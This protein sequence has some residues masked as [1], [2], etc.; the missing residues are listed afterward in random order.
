[1]KRILSKVLLSII[2]VI[3]IIVNFFPSV[4]SYAYD[5]KSDIRTIG[6]VPSDLTGKTIILHSNDVHGAIEKYAY[7]AALKKNLQE[8]G[9]EVILVD[10]GDYSGGTF[11]VSAFR[12]RDAITAMNA[13]DYDIA[14]LG[15]HEFDYGYD[16][17]KSNISIADFQ[18]ICA[19]IYDSNNKPIANPNTIYVTKSRLKLGLF[20]LTTPKTKI[21]VSPAYV[22]DLNF[23]SGT[24]LYT[25]AQDQVEELKSSGCDLII[26]LSHLGVDDDAAIVGDRSVDVFSHTKGIDIMLDAHSHAVMTKGADGEPVLSTGTQFEN[27]GIVII[28]NVGKVIEDQYLI[29]FK[30]IQNVLAPDAETEA[31][32]SLIIKGVQDEYGAVFAKSEV[33]L[34]GEEDPGNRTQETNMGDF[35]TDALIWRACRMDGVIAVSKDHVVSVIN[36]GAIKEGIAKGDITKNDLLGALPYGNTIS[37][38]YLT[39]AKLLETM[40]AATYSAPQAS[41]SYPQTAGIKFTVDTTVPFDKG[42]VYA[43]SDNHRPAKIQRVTINEICG[44]PFSLDDTYAVVTN[45]YCAVGG[46]SYGAFAEMES[47]Y[48]TGI[49]ITDAIVDYIETEHGGVIPESI[50]GTARNEQTIITK[51]N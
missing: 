10:S 22:K 9:A 14:T 2:L 50:Y 1:M 29:N 7:V 24:E 23:L 25:C 47:N 17:L 40:E 33:N 31:A 11:Y 27:V 19:D 21:S 34:V 35:I 20:G 43:T 6:A 41:G 44:K 5:F 48:D 8:R 45:D 3:A 32:I 4:T 15:N 39:G 51:S 49:I 28:D 18:I 46:G 42:D 26:C 16:V 38:V 36:G 12:G 37:I 30:S 13:A